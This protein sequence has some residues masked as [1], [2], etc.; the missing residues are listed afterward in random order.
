MKYFPWILA[1]LLAGNLVDADNVAGVDRLL[2]ASKQVSICF[3]T[4]Q[5]FSV[6]PWEIGVPEFVV[7][8]RKEKSI[9][10]TKSS[11]DNRS[12]SIETLS[13]ANGVIYMQGFEQGR[14][15]SIVIHED[16]GTMSA[17]VARDGTATTVFGACT[18]AN[19][20]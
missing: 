11:G 7:I 2:C 20:D 15:F 8:D 9:S 16:M 6:Q 18:D 12:T 5:C 4:G 14:A 13:A 17:A 3:E 10:T 19:H 1:G